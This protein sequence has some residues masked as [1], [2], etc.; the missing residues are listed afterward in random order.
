MTREEEANILKQRII[1]SCNGHGQYTLT[2]RRI[3]LSGQTATI[4]FV[5][6]DMKE[7]WMSSNW[8]QS[9]TNTIKSKIM[10]FNVCG[11]MYTVAIIN[12]TA[13]KLR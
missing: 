8:Y 1:D 2:I 13:Y 12:G 5:I 9:V 4:D 6:S 3:S 10:C 11:N 7:S